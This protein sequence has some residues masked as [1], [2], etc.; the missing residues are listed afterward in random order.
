[1]VSDYLKE[2]VREVTNSKEDIVFMD[3]VLEFH[4]CFRGIHYMDSATIH[5]IAYLS[6]ALT[7]T[8][9]Y[10]YDTG[11]EVA[12]RI[13]KLPSELRYS[14]ETDKAFENIFVDLF[15]LDPMKD[16][17]EEK[18]RS[19]VFSVGR[20]IYNIS[21]GHFEDYNVSNIQKAATTL[22]ELVEDL[23][24]QIVEESHL[25]DR[26]GVSMLR[27]Y[28]TTPSDYDRIEDLLFQVLLD[29]K[30]PFQDNCERFSKSLRQSDNSFSGSFDM[31]VQTYFNNSTLFH[32]VV[33]KYYEIMK[34]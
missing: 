2:K 18:S 1:M 15:K 30:T 22:E 34:K 31:A 3:N 17:F 27:A 11:E 12:H 8:I 5:I 16:L 19:E 33:K 29:T 24:S 6:E 14:S 10:R 9:E 13:F 21:N 26:V 25:L 23:E 4:N 32:N 28:L 7:N 20:F